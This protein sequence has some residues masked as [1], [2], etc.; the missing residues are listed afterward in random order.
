MT[1]RTRPRAMARRFGLIAVAAGITSLLIGPAPA[2]AGPVG[3]T[4]IAV[5]STNPLTPTITL[6]N[7]TGQPCRIAG[8]TFGTI[9]IDTLTQ[10]TTAITPVPVSISSDDSIGTIVA[11]SLKT[12]DP[13]GSV[14]LRL[15]VHPVGTTGH[16]LETVMWSPAGL[17]LG[18]LYPIAAQGAL[19]M[20]VTYTPPGLPSGGVPLCPNATTTGGAALAAAGPTAKASGVDVPAWLIAAV[21]SILVILIGLL[22]IVLVRRRRPPTANTGATM[23]LPVAGIIAVLLLAAA[24]APLIG[25]ARAANATISV[26]P[27]LKDA[28][29]AC[30]PI[31]GRPGNDPGNLLP[32]LNAPGVSVQIVPANGDQT[33]E[34][35]VDSKTI[36][37]FWDPNDRHAYTGGGNADPCTSLYHEFNHA[38]ED[39][40]GGQDRSPCVTA[41][42]NSAIPT[43]E[44]NATRVQNQLRVKLGLPPR[45]TY[46][47][48]ALPD[49]PCLPKDQQ[50]KNPKN[51]TG[52]GCGDTNGDPHLHTYDLRRYDFQAVGEFLA[53]TDTSGAFRIQVRQQP[54][55]A[56]RTVAV[57]TAIAMNVAGDRVEVRLAPRSLVLLVDGEPVPVG[58]TRLA[59]G[60]RI[61]P[62]PGHYTPS[63]EVTWP[64]GS[65]ATIA[66]IGP[67]GLHLTV[68]PAA[69]L[70]GELSGLLG[71]YDGDPAND[72]R[73]RNGAPITDASFKTLYPAYADS[74]RIDA[75][76]SLFTYDA[77]TSTATYLDPTFPD[78]AAAPEKQPGYAQARALCQQAGVTDPALLANCALDVTLTGRPDFAQAAVDSQALVTVDR[79]QVGQQ[80]VLTIATPGDTATLT[81]PGTAGTK[82][83]IDITMSDLPNECGELRLSGPDGAGIGIGCVIN[84]VGSVDTTLLPSTGQYTLSLG[85][86]QNATGS[87]RLSIIPVVDTTAPADE[88][89]PAVTATVTG[90]GAIAALTFTGTAGQNVFID[91]PASTLPNE[92]GVLRLRAPDGSSIAS[93]C[94]INGVGYVDAT[95]LPVSGMYTVM[96]DPSGRGS[97]SSTVRVLTTTNIAGTIAVGGADVVATITR[98]GQVARYTFTGVAGQT[99]KLDVPASTLPANCGALRL[100]E[101]NGDQLSIGCVVNGTGGIDAI[102]LPVS[103]RYTIVVDPPGTEI[104][105]TT[106][107]LR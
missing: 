28:Y 60:G 99:V 13:G 71:N 6:T 40:T 10:G 42:G 39:T 69:A 24:V 64:D 5:G 107:R 63:V 81:F 34:A 25:P 65:I 21:A 89:G 41:K 53:T 87:M 17:G 88:N 43:N 45:K 103:G 33:H 68:Q 80:A 74:W 58:D 36:I 78:A 48:T 85:S 101:P 14:T 3:G 46:G 16:A 92:C 61:S 67:W 73:P 9:A 11:L 38:H 56:S 102:K 27:G 106:L 91:V 23:T 96:F 7:R 35:A 66:P 72:I 62:V 55:L 29:A 97:G 57:N 15:P 70:K 79:G 105:S 2:I 104:G 37:I 49:G 90:P 12:L 98:V 4:G 8:T 59:A 95:T 26:D 22:I 47:D 31:F 54:F 30:G 52:A 93:A 20:S 75:A 82:I 83:Y 51:C 100:L 44:V 50:P 19:R 18:S 94:V 32:G 1:A 77:G 86:R 76:S 84:G